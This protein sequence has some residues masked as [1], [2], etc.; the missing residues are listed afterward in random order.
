ME[1][2]TGRSGSKYDQNIQYANKINWEIHTVE[3]ILCH[4]IVLKQSSGTF[5]L[6]RVF[7]MSQIFLFLV[8]LHDFPENSKQLVLQY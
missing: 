7:M 2:V 8:S 5:I 1:G 3:L 6:G 4:I